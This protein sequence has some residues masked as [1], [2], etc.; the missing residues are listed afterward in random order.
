MIETKL[1]K[2]SRNIFKEF[3]KLEKQVQKQ[4]ILIEE[5]KSLLNDIAKY[6]IPII[7]N[8]QVVK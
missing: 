3:E 1:D 5:M 7:N 8:L 4:E 6:E 2:L